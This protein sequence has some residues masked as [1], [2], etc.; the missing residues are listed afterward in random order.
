MV[1]FALIKAVVGVSFS[2]LGA[3]AFSFLGIPF[4]ISLTIP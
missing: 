4:P 2:I 1:R 3:L